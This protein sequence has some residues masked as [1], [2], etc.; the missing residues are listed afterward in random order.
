MDERRDAEGVLEAPGEGAEAGV[1][2]VW[3]L[4]A[5]HQ[6][7]GDPRSP[8]ELLTAYHEVPVFAAGT[9]EGAV[10]EVQI[11]VVAFSRR[12]QEHI[13]ED[14]AAAVGD[15]RRACR[16][17]GHQTFVV[18]RHLT[19]LMDV[20]KHGAVRTGLDLRIAVHMIADG[21]RQRYCEQALHP[22]PI[23]P[24][25][26]IG[27]VV[28]ICEVVAVRV[29]I[30]VRTEDDSGI[31]CKRIVRLEAR[32]SSQLVRNHVVKPPLS[33]REPRDIDA[34]QHHVHLRNPLHSSYP[35]TLTIGRKNPHMAA[36]CVSE[37]TTVLSQT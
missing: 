6:V 37:R 24:P 17:G 9:R 31:D 34:L 28:R 10:W 22:V 26:V 12:K 32:P 30:H 16:D 35:D 33:R 1:V 14:I 5:D 21:D 11:E 8:A 19:D 15:T 36:I 4:V 13:R 20:G 18:D 3:N 29:D 23:T 25:S 7:A 27:P 2:V